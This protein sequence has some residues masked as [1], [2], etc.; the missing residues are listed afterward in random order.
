MRAHSERAHPASNA[1]LAH[2]RA[3][4]ART[5]PDPLT[6]VNGSG[7]VEA[8]PLTRVNGLALCTVHKTAAQAPA[9]TA[10]DTGTN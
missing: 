5:V 4:R 10:P 1:A 7:T 6:R 9:K 8:N 2:F 3:S